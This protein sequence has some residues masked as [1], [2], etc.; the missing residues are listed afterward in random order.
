MKIFQHFCNVLVPCYKIV[1]LNFHYLTF[2]IAL[3][4]ILFQKL[5]NKNVKDKT[6][7]TPK[8]THTPFMGNQGNMFSWHISSKSC[9]SPSPLWRWVSQVKSLFPKEVRNSYLPK[10]ASRICLRP[11]SHPIFHVFVKKTFNK[12]RPYTKNLNGDFCAE[13]ES[14]QNVTKI[15]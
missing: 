11:T 3:C 6:F 13:K 12:K 8:Q 10:E 9:N 7:E 1:I 5:H 4:N 2:H 14:S 15:L